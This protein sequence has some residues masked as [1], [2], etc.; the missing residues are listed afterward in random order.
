MHLLVYKPNIAIFHG[1]AVILEA[2]RHISLWMLVIFTAF[3]RQSS[4]VVN[5]FIIVYAH[6]VLIDSHARIINHSFA[7]PFCGSKLY[8][9][10]L[11][12]FRLKACVYFRRMYPVYGNACFLYGET[13]VPFKGNRRSPCMVTVVPFNGN[14]RFLLWDTRSSQRKR[15][16]AYGVMPG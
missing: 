6:S 10:R 1:I 14:G 16:R 12:S 5:G 11:P 8:I 4:I 3:W 13:L 2:N 15:V 9:V 7:H